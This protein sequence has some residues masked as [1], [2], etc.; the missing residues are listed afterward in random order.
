[1]FTA[2]GWQYFRDD[3]I[4][5]AV[6]GVR[7]APA[8]IKRP[9]RAAILAGLPHRFATVRALALWDRGDRSAAIGGI[10]AAAS[11]ARPA[12][13]RRLVRISLALGQTKL[14]GELLAELPAG[15]PRRPMLAAL[16]ALREGQ[17][18]R[19]AA[20]VD[21]AVD[22]A[23]DAG[24]PGRSVETRALERLRRRLDAELAALDPQRRPPWRSSEQAF[25]PTPARVMHLVTNSLPHTNAGYTVRT[26][27]IARAQQ[28]AG[29]DPRIVT[30]LGFPVAQGI[31]RAADCER[32]DGVPYYRLLPDRA[33]PRL[34]DKKLDLHAELAA[35]L[36]EKLKPAV[37]H[38]ASNHVN[39]QAA[40]A[41]RDRYGL[42]FVYEVR[43]FIEESWLS[44]QSSPEA[45]TSDRY[46]LARELETYCMRQADAVVTLGGGMKAEII[47]RGLT[48]GLVTVVPNAVDDAFLAPL[49]DPAYARRALGATSDDV[50]VGILSTFFPHEGIDYLVRAIAELRR[51]GS[52]VRLALIG[53]GT[54][55]AALERL[56]AELGLREITVFTGRVPFSEVR[57]YYAAIDIFAVPRTDDQVCHM[58]TP[59]KP[60]EAMASARPV[61]ASAVGGLTEIITDGTT[62]VLAP[63]EDPAALAD[64]I[65][66]LLYDEALRARLGKAARDWVASD[67]TWSRNAERYRTIYGSLGAL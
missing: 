41:L 37:L 21:A 25:A 24:A 8:T 65:E 61:V 20:I 67:R 6:L 40:L 14:A 36:A 57:H 66:P 50:V 10:R 59:L 18:R 32:V 17:L 49:P 31:V 48:A 53:D 63:P 13:R 45:G 15:D 39:A 51:R 27:M 5:A 30:A 60:I 47:G 55:R 43:G 56:V 52:R 19:A 3:G 62:G 38:A 9:L 2:L 35:A 54:E 1:M 44:R 7:L 29:L 16:I 4:N 58:V 42:P 26:H 11:A 33:L 12:T 46:R 64:A 23:V 34:P 28:R 22:T